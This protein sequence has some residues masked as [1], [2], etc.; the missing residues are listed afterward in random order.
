M[1]RRLRH[2]RLT[3][4]GLLLLATPINADAHP[5]VFVDA[6]AEI[7][8]DGAGQITAIRNSWTFDEAFSAYAKQGLK[9]LAN[10][11]LTPE[12][13]EALARVNIHSLALYKF[14]TY[15]RRAGKL[16]PVGVGEG[17]KLSDDGER[18][19]LTF[20]V[21]PPQPI[22][23]ASGP[24]TFAVY[25]PEYFVAMSF[26]KDHP[27][28]LVGAPAVCK[29]SLF[30]PTGLTPAAAALIARVPASQ[31]SLPPELEAM[32]GGIESRDGC[33]SRTGR[34]GAHAGYGAFFIKRLIT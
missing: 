4:A 22:D 17:Q 24:L 12:S 34:K 29:Q 13:L 7:V 15:Q 11:R 23:P 8:F 14:F 18:L 25:D 1:Y 27:I 6:R 19:T 28:R 20:T 3:I 10:G 2:P 21:M 32:T 16:E 9:R 26:V 30:T 5:H 33:P 31:R